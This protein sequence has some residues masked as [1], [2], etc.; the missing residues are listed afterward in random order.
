MTSPRPLVPMSAGGSKRISSTVKETTTASHSDSGHGSAPL[1]GARMSFVLT[2]GDGIVVR[3][4]GYLREM[5]KPSSPLP[6][7]VR[8]LVVLSSV[9]DGETENLSQADGYHQPSPSLPP[10]SS[11]RTSSSG[12]RA[13]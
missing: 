6:S 10:H 3:C 1:S 8:S 7:G 2:V 13:R 11:K 9:S 12:P 4:S 5:E